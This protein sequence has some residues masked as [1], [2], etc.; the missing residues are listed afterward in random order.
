MTGRYF[1]W[2]GYNC[3]SDE[4]YTWYRWPLIVITSCKWYMCS[5]IYN[6]INQLVAAGSSSHLKLFVAITVYNYIYSNYMAKQPLKGYNGYIANDDLVAGFMFFLCSSIDMGWCSPI[7]KHGFHG[8]WRVETTN[9]FGFGTCIAMCKGWE[10]G[11]ELMLLHFMP[12]LHFKLNLEC[13]AV[14]GPNHVFDS[15]SDEYIPTRLISFALFA[16][17][18]VLILPS[19]FKCW[20]TPR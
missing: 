14:V 20:L 15:I 18:S 8:G 4:S 3:W 11:A 17:L 1:T 6:I 7:H 16:S 9:I 13:Q 5:Y 10:N 2:N 12:C 19:S